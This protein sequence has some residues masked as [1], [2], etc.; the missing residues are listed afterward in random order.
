MMRTRIWAGAVALATVLAA[1]KTAQA[2][3]S[4]D[5]SFF[6]THTSATAGTALSLGLFNLPIIPLS[7]E[8]TAAVPFNGDGYATTFD[9]RFSPFGTTIGAGAG[10][11]NLGRTT[12][13][14]GIYDVILGHALIPR[15]G[16]EAREYFGPNRPSSFMVGLRLTL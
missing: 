3:V 6:D 12:T 10:F 9:L 7:G 11:G 4:I 5:G 8:L 1:G 15:V 16:L 2:D 14:A 13:T